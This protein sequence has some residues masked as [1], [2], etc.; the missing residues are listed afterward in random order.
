[1]L[2]SNDRICHAKTDKF[3]MLWYKDL[4]CF[5]VKIVIYGVNNCQKSRHAAA[6]KCHVFNGN[7]T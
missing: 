5:K 3:V 6:N 4:P 2:K 1:M 7:P